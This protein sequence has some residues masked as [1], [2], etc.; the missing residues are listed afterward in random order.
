MKKALI[1]ILICINVGLL[2]A[3]MLGTFAPKADAQ[4]YR[5]ASDYLMMSGS[6]TKSSENVYVIDLS[7]RRL[8]GWQWDKTTRRLTRLGGRNLRTDFKRAED[9]QPDDEPRPGR[10]PGRR[11]SRRQRRY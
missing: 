5:P 3:L 2:A 6:M 9:E 11:P 1:A 4:V 10:R 8:V 7:R